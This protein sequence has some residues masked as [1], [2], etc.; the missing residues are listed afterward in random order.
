MEAV[1]LPAVAQPVCRP[2]L[3][4]AER[5]FEEVGRW[6]D[7][8]VYGS[9]EE[10]VEAMNAYLRWLESD[11]GQGAVACRMGLDRGSG[12]A[13][14]ILSCGLLKLKCTTFEPTSFKGT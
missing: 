13:P 11:P 14:A 1:G 5:V 6:V 9:V 10:K 2:E 4:P 3:N 7:G 12:P 8:R